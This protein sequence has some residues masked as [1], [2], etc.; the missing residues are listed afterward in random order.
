MKRKSSSVLQIQPSTYYYSYLSTK[1]NGQKNYTMQP[2][3]PCV[4][5]ASLFKFI[6]L[7]LIDFL[8]NPVYQ[9][10]NQ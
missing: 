2:R 10:K 9:K 1:F 6:N 4:C 3:I 7:C 5:M 8:D